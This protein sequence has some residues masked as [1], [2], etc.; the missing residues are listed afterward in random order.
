[1]KTSFENISGSIGHIPNPLKPLSTLGVHAFIQ[2]LEANGGNILS[3]MCV[4]GFI[5]L[6]LF[7]I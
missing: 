5:R 2:A 1:M 4:C 6:K 3:V 7:M